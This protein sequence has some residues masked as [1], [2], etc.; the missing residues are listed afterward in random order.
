[1]TEEEEVVREVLSLRWS[2]RGLVEAAVQTGRLDVQLQGSAGLRGRD[3]LT[4]ITETEPVD[5]KKQGGMLG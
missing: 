3:R 4:N 5:R 2:C 1:V